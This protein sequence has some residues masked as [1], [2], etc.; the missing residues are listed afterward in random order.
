MRRDIQLLRGLAV[1]LVVLF[2]ADLGLVT[3]GYLGVDVFFVVSGFLITSIILKGISANNFSFSAFYLRRAKRLLPAL[4]CTLAITALFAYWFIAGTQ[5]ND[6][7]AQLIG[8]LT[9]SSNLVLPTQVGYF[10]SSAEGKPLLHI[11][12][13][14]LEEQY[15]FFLPLLLFF[16]P[17]SKQFVVLLLLTLGSIV[18][19]FSWAS[20]GSG[21]TPFL[22]RFFDVTISESAFYLF[23]TRAW[24]LLAGSLC[25]WL[26]INNPISVSTAVKFGSLLTI[27]IVSCIGLDPIHPR[28]DALLVVIATSLILLGDSSWLP[29]SRTAD[30]MGKIGDYSY[31]VYLVHWPIF[32]F[33]Y[34]AYAG[35]VPL[36]IKI[37]LV[38]ISLLLGYG[39][40]KYIETPFRYGWNKKSSK[41][42]VWLGLSTLAVVAIPI[43]MAVSAN[44]NS[45]KGVKIDFVEIRAI[46]YGLSERCDG[47]M[48]NSGVS[49]ECITGSHPKLAIWGDSYAMHL[50]PG[51]ANIGHDIIQITK[52]VCGPIIG[53]SPIGGE[54]T[55]DWAVGCSRFN[56]AAVQIIVDSDSITH[57]VLASEFS[58]Y[59]KNSDGQFLISEGVI[60]KDR[61]RA[62]EAMIA[63]IENLKNA[64]KIPI[65]FSPPPRSG[66][67]IGEC[68]ERND[69][70]LVSFRGKCDVL[71]TDYL[72]YDREIRSALKYIE[73]KTN[74]KV[75]W[76]DDLLCDDTKCKSK[77]GD[78]YVYRDG[79]HLSVSGSEK[80]LSNLDLIQPELPKN[81][82]Q[83]Q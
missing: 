32:A 54:Y 11:W 31:S 58:R 17:K 25:A 56:K 24:E 6:F 26:M 60:K 62:M 55:E 78:T 51:L 16:T 42:W 36:G 1:S 28:G 57:V 37:A 79:G 8:S 14:S 15:Y 75:I 40:Y 3:S 19:C 21:A 70:G 67:N 83:Y 72:A 20:S 44:S 77:I 53:L 35:Q 38:F 61:S 43:P 10:E 12:S 76:F 39:Q 18:W 23:P 9:F 41:T 13:L 7:I 71:V 22:W 29:R 69:T 81:K 52:S 59:F 47:W 80:L 73:S 27:I 66:F 68:L 65:I 45:T 63:T 74:V 33:S 5:W 50:V 48:N 2:H 64:G 30:Y 46:N 49:P 82:R 4:Y 34:L